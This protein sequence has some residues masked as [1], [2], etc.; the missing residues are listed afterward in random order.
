MSSHIKG[1]LHGL[2]C[3]ILLIALCTACAFPEK[4]PRPV[5]TSEKPRPQTGI[6][7]PT[8]ERDFIHTVRW[9]GESLS[10]I[11]KWYTGDIRKWGVLA[12]ANGQ[13]NPNR[14]FLGDRIRLPESLVKTRK[15]LPKEFVEEFFRK[16][17]EKKPSEEA[18][19]NEE[20]L[21]LFGPRPGF[22]N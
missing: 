12:R 15:P 17:Q 13:R 11:A 9:P 19:G 18:S 8:G 10:I 1:T 3:G 22:V 4:R 7:S 20:A 6:P 16:P 14:I 5:S 2:S 21:T